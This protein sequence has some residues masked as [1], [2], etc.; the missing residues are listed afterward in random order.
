MFLMVQAGLK[1]SATVRYAHADTAG[2]HIRMKYYNKCN[3]AGSPVRLWR[4]AF[5]RSHCRT[6]GLCPH[7]SIRSTWQ[8]TSA[9]FAT[10][11]NRW[12]LAHPHSVRC[13][14]KI[15]NRFQEICKPANACRNAEAQGRCRKICGQF[16]TLYTWVIPS[17]NGMTQKWKFSR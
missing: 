13:P 17:G 6:A 7:R 2:G 12:F 11:E 10:W 4:T 8:S 14:A 1:E 9:P 5:Q 15:V 16:G 3:N